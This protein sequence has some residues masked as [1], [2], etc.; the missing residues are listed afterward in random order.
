MEPGLQ[1]G[2]FKRAG[3]GKSQKSMEKDGG[4]VY[5]SNTVLRKG[6]GP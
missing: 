5:N 6:G 1:I 3:M 2:L 4:K